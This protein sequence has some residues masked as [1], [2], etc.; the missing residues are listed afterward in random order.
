MTPT[1]PRIQTS[2]THMPAA[3]NHREPELTQLGQP[4]GGSER[5][6]IREAG[7]AIE[8]AAEAAD[9]GLESG[10]GR[11]GPGEFRRAPANFW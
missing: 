5:E 7:G 6:R 11:V 8:L 3:G 1:Q 2:E 4:R 10:S 9:S